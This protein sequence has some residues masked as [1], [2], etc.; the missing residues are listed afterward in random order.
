M[1]EWKT[2]SKKIIL[3][4]GKYLKV[5]NHQI[6]LPD[7]KIIENWPWVITPDFVN[8]L[9]LNKEKKF[10]CFRQ[11]KYAVKGTSLA[12]VGGHIEPNENPLL[13]AKRE[14]LEETGYSSD[15]WVDLGNFITEANRGGS[16][17]FFYLGLNAE[18]IAEPDSD[19]LEE[20]ELLLMSFEE[21]KQSVLNGEFKVLSWTSGVLLAIQYLENNHFF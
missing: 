21:I 2:L 9:A 16:R 7:G 10:V 5:E 4:C 12:P 20:Q 1:T 18:K 13:A 6:E 19:D 11:T 15:E 14:L 3:D 8:V 17:G